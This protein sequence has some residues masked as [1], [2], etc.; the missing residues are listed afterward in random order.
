MPVIETVREKTPLEKDRE[1]ANQA[2]R[3][4]F[5][6]KK[7]ISNP[8]FN[9]ELLWND[10]DKNTMERIKKRVDISKKVSDPK[11]NDV[12]FDAHNIVGFD[13]FATNESLPSIDD[14]DRDIQLIHN[15]MVPFFGSTVKQN[16]NDNGFTEG[17]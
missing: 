11:I 8:N 1:K 13:A 16:V 10:L 3:V 12:G 15:N 2:F 6:R 7:E 14:M 5:F 9:E 4:K 17:I